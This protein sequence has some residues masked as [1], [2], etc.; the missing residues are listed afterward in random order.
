MSV[1]DNGVNTW[2]VLPDLGMV[3]REVL[4]PSF[5]RKNRFVSITCISRDTRT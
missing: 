3:G 1:R 5:L 4:T 2:G